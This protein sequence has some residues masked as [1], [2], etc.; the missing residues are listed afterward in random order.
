MKS[1]GTTDVS[2]GNDKIN[3]LGTRITTWKTTKPEKTRAKITAKIKN[4]K[5]LTDVKELFEK[6]TSKKR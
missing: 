2:K 4:D 3:K 5:R 1:A 6:T